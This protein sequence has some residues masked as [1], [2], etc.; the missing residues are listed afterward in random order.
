MSETLIA[1]N[2]IGGSILH[3][4]GLQTNYDE[5][6]DEWLTLEKAKDLFFTMNKIRIGLARAALLDKD[7]PRG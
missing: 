3:D 5:D 2:C 1:N 7:I 6:S 4:L